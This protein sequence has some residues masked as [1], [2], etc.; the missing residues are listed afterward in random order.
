M[1]KRRNLIG[2]IF[3][4]NIKMSSSLSKILETGINAFKVTIFKI[5][6]NVIEFNRI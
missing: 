3:L 5:E 2:R 1:G 4:E 6:E